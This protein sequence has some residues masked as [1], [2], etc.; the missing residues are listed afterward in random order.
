[1]T[2]DPELPLIFTEELLNSSQLFTDSDCPLNACI[3]VADLYALFCKWCQREK[4]TPL[5]RRDFARILRHHWPIANSNGE[6]FT[7]LRAAP[8]LKLQPRLARNTFPAP[9]RAAALTALE[10]GLSIEAAQSAAAQELLMLGGPEITPSHTIVRRWYESA[11]GATYVSGERGIINQANALRGAERKA[12]RNDHGPKKPPPR[13]AGKKTCRYCQ[14][15]E[16]IGITLVH[17][18]KHAEVNAANADFPDEHII[19][20]LQ[21][22]VATPAS[23]GQQEN[24]L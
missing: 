2:E 8:G 18:R 15:A 7:H 22:M 4:Q 20:W 6:R 13:I 9:V 1:M 14:V 19:N 3:R 12:F 11:H 21:T 10:R 16:S 17:T 24:A 5:K 23:K